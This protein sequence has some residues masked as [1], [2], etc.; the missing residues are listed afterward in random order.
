MV[1]WRKEEW[2]IW[3]RGVEE[4]MVEGRDGSGGGGEEWIRG[5][6]YYRHSRSSCL[7]CGLL[8]R[9][10]FQSQP[11]VHGILALLHRSVTSLSR[12]LSAAGG[13]NTEKGTHEEL[14]LRRR[15]QHLVASASPTVTEQRWRTHEELD[16]CWCVLH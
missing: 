1:W 8:S 3:R 10:L 13:D 11:P 5:G 14:E 16:P 9:W 2:S 15:L 6:R 4:Q 7:P 12:P